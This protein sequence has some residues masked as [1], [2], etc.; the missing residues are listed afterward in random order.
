LIGLCALQT[1][2]FLQ[3]IVEQDLKALTVER[4][5]ALVFQALP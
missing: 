2:C 1:G 3:E 5:D 4:L